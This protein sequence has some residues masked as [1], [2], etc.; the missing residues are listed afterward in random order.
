MSKKTKPSI[1][2]ATAAA[3][4][5]AAA[6]AAKASQSTDPSD[7]SAATPSTTHETAPQPAAS[8][9]ITPKAGISNA[10]SRTMDDKISNMQSILDVALECLDDLRLSFSLVKWD[11]MT[12]GSRSKKDHQRKM[13]NAKSFAEK[14]KKVP[15]Q[16]QR[17]KG[18]GGC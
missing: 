13:A 18:Q 2:T 11:E 16:A 15:C 4:T 12:E 6:K 14:Y 9:L 1:S 10:Y 8:T 5:V 17:E 3:A 7:A